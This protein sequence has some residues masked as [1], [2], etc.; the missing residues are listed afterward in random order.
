MRPKGFADLADLPEDERIAI[1]AATAKGGAIVG[2]CVDDEIAKV[3][4]YI[5]KITA[6][7]VRV[8]DRTSGPVKGVVTLRVGPLEN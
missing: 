1:I 7:G 5:R 8:I 6:L 2:V 4:R 3:E